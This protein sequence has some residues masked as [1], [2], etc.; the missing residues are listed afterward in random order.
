[1]NF[2][3][4]PNAP[5]EMFGLIPSKH[6]LKSYRVEVRPLVSSECQTCR[7]MVILRSGPRDIM[8]YLVFLLYALI[9]LPHKVAHFPYP[10]ELLF[11]RT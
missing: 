11:R 5:S 4:L 9:R 6:S 8:H 7:Q 3:D 10:F 2:V 1:M